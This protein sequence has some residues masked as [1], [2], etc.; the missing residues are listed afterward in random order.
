MQDKQIGIASNNLGC[1]STDGKFEKFVVFRIA[2]VRDNLA[3][4]YEGGIPNKYFKKL[5]SLFFNNVPIKLSP[6][7]YIIQFVKCSN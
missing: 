7:Y 6:S 5:E 4:F 1:M 2:T 3:Y